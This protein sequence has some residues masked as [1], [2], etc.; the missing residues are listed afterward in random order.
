MNY[1]HHF[2]KL[3]N[4]NLASLN[5]RITLKERTTL[6]MSTISKSSAHK[7]ELRSAGPTESVSA[8]RTRAPLPP[9][10]RNR[11]RLAV[12][13]DTTSQT[14]IDGKASQ[15]SRTNTH[16]LIACVAIELSAA[17]GRTQS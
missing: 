3:L 17:M 8:D 15:L 10:N 5:A 12:R 14:Y 9:L 11:Q 7:N 1:P 16:L 6:P 4:P 13:I 2:D